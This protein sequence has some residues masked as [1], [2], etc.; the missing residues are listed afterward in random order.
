MRNL[1][2]VLVL[3][4]LAFAAWRAWFS[5]PE[6]PTQ[7][8][9]SG[10]PTIE[11]FASATSSPTSAVDGLPAGADELQLACISLG[12][13]PNRVDVQDAETALE[14]SGFAVRQRTADGDVWLGYWVYLDAIETQ[15]V[16][17]TMVD[18]LSNAGISEAYVIADADS[19]NI[20]SLGVFSERARAQQ[21][22]ADAQT[23][24]M[25]PVI[26]NRSQPGEVFWLDVTANGGRTFE[27]VELPEINVDPELQYSSCIDPNE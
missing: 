11:L 12:P 18:Q 25:S 4:N 14:N 10:A 24:E 15:E 3:V 20:V 21:R 2:L 1:F 7:L 26:A 27:Q 13:F 22:F 23:L 16:A 17:A 19:G 6:Y 5:G 9:S 8:I